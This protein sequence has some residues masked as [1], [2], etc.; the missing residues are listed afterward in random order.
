MAAARSA[1]AAEPAR[2]FLPRPH[3]GQRRLLAERERFNVACM[4]RRF[5]KTKL[6]LVLAAPLLAAGMPV[7]WFAPGYRYVTE[8]FRDA[9]HYL[10][11]LIARKDVQERRLELVTGGVFECWT[12]DGPDP[13]RGRRYRMAI[14]DEAAMV[15]DLRHRWQTAIRPTLTDYRGE[16]WF[17]STPK[18]RND[19]A[20]LFDEAAERPG[21]ARWQMPSVMNPH[22]DPAEIEAARLD[23][24]EL[25]FRQEYGAEFV[26]FA[27]TAVKREWLKFA[28][29]PASLTDWRIGMGV[30]LAL[31]QRDGADWT[32]IVVVAIH[33]D[34]RI[35]IL[36]AY[37]DR[38]TFRGILKLIESVADQWKPARVNVESVQFQA[39]VVQELLRETR[40]PV[41]PYRPDKDKFTRFLP[42]QVRFE[43]GLFTLADSLPNTFADELLSFPVGDH[44]DF[45]DALGMAY[46]AA[47]SGG[48]GRV[49]VAGRMETFDA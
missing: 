16:A 8:V 9:T 46:Q 39:A 17:F 5:G 3:A 27:G 35:F 1:P 36:D 47:A 25:V 45:V 11:P 14:V 23:L 24:P 32:A 34:G 6:G 31:S 4:G 42:L 30:D 2:I 26:D 13:A 21:W 44:D 28:P 49:A 12:L 37:R 18:G 43:Q 33:S 15:R 29:R 38:L 19:F 48:P 41:T 40:L 20:A 7:A 22:L 10:G